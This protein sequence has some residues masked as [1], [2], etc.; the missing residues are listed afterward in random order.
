[1]AYRVACVLLLLLMAGGASAH[2]PGES[3]V[4][5][6]VSDPELSGEFHIRVADI[7]KAVEL[8]TDGDGTV[9]DA[10]VEAR[11]TDIFDHLGQRLYFYANGERHRIEPLDMRFFAKPK[12]R[13]MAIEFGVPTLTPVP[14]KIEVEYRFLY[15]GADPA[16]RPMLLQESNTRMRLAENE[17]F[18]SL[19]FEPGGERHSLSLVPPPRGPLFREFVLHG[20]YMMLADLERVLLIGALLLPV[21]VRRQAGAWQPQ[22]GAVHV[23]RGVAATAAALAVG[24]AAALMIRVQYDWRPTPPYDY[25][26]LALSLA[27]VA[28]DNFRP[29]PWVRRWQVALVAGVLQGAGRNDYTALVG[30]NKGLPEIVLSGFALGVALAVIVVAAVLVPIL[31]LVRDM[32][33]Y[34]LAALRLGSVLLVG[35]SAA[36]F[37]AKVL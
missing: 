2:R 25:G 28:V 30:L 17:W 19:V 24:M 1:M 37:T 13:Q 7:A 3:Y 5:I 21:V 10:E 8:D 23:A 6:S 15:D 14:E 12:V 18:V 16:H 4:Y 34:R 27:L 20:F 26:L 29:L 33:L 22:G 11:R 35:V 36:W 31:V 9:S 32:R